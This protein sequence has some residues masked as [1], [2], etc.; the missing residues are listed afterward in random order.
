MNTNRVILG[1]EGG[2]TKTEW[3]QS[4]GSKVIASGVFG[5]G[6]LR[7]ISDETLLGYFQKMPDEADAVGIFLAG[8]VNSADRRRAI[9]L[10]KQRWPKAFFLAGSDRESGFETIL[11]EGPGILAIAGTGSSIMGL[12][13]GRTEFASG[14]GHLLGDAGSGYDIGLSALRRVIHDYDMRHEV[15]PV[16]HEI[17]RQLS[18]NTLPDLITWVA[19]AD[20]KSIAALAPLVFASAASGDEEMHDIVRRGAWQVA[21]YTAAVARRLNLTQPRIGLMGGMF[22][23][24]HY[25]ESFE[26][27][28]RSFGIDASFHD[29]RQNG[30]YGAARL[31]AR[32]SGAILPEPRSLDDAPLAD[33]HHATTEQRNPRSELLHTMTAMQIAQLFISE[34]QVVHQALTAMLPQLAQGIDLIASCIAAGGRLFYVGAGTSGRLGV[35]DAS[36]IP[37]T[38]GTDPSLVQAIMAGGPQAIAGAYEAAED[39]AAEGAETAEMRGI[40]AGD[41]VCGIAASGRTPFVIGCLEAA[42]QRGAQT[43]FLTCNPAR[44][45]Q[46]P[47]W[48]IEIDCPTGPELITGSTRLKAGTATK[49]ALNLLSSGAMIRL[50]KVYRNYMIAMNPSNAKLRDRAVRMVADIRACSLDEAKKLLETHHGDISACVSDLLQS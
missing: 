3:Q 26:Q 24:H 39:D 48:D 30:A 34:E 28:T 21:E 20:K 22:R 6:N 17:L 37:P 23:A 1:I 33:V 45:Q 40:R 41:V 11:G 5:T 35:L 12:H 14:W 36:E 18:C 42:R 19:D 49:L 29:S 32:A 38:F 9:G 2:G 16:A 10:A 43:I 31:V 13:E 46:N 47:P 44:P 8:C 27:S 50:G 25:R 15:H 7:L 4:Q